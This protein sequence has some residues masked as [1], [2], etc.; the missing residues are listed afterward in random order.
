[1]PSVATLT[2]R[3]NKWYNIKDYVSKKKEKYKVMKWKKK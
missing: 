3:P 1:M 2:I